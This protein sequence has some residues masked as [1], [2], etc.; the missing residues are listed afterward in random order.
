MHLTA[1]HADRPTDR[2]RESLM[3]IGRYASNES[4]ADYFNNITC[5]SERLGPWELSTRD[6][7]NNTNT[8]I[9]E[10]RNMAKVI[11]TAPLGRRPSY[12]CF[13]S[14]NLVQVYF[15]VEL[16]VVSL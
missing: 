3:T 7:K 13:S 6:S 5:F 14:S 8:T 2:P 4:D 10:A 9:Y 1:R 15:C 16:D 11:T 12:V